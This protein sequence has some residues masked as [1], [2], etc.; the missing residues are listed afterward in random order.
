LNHDNDVTLGYTLLRITLGIKHRGHGIS[1]ILAGP[2]HF[3][4]A[5]VKQFDSTPLPHFAVAG[6]AYALPW[7]EALVGLFILLGAATR[8]ALI[9][10]ALLIVALTFGSTLHQDWDVAGLQLIYAAVYFALLA[11]RQYN[12]FSVD[13]AVSSTTNPI[14]NNL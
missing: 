13:R 8:I 12:L 7:M 5:L 3:A 1:R 10:G 11:L 14:A 9:A 2:S 4:T 6:F